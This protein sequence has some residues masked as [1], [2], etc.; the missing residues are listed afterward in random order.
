MGNMSTREVSAPVQ[1]S[2]SVSR[3]MSHQLKYSNLLCSKDQNPGLPVP[4]SVVYRRM[5]AHMLSHRLTLTYTY[6]W[7]YLR[8]SFLKR[9]KIIFFSS[10]NQWGYNTSHWFDLYWSED[11]RLRVT[12]SHFKWAPFGLLS[13]YVPLKPMLGHGF[14]FHWFWKY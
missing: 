11:L 3:K 12:S 5:T 14:T 8:S 1:I 6:I 13:A 2:V 4:Y 9:P 10:C 7:I